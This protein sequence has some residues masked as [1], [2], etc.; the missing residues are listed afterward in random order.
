MHSVLTGC[1][2]R[3][4]LCQHWDMVSTGDRG[5][6]EDAQAHYGVGVGIYNVSE[7]NTLHNLSSERILICFH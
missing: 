6:H 1:C 5:H 4:N 3:Q 7:V 2:C